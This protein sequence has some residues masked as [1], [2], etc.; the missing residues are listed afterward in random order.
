MTS[1]KD[2]KRKGPDPKPI[3]RSPIASTTGEEQFWMGQVLWI[4][5]STGR[6]EGEDHS[7]NGELQFESAGDGAADKARIPCPFCEEPVF[8]L[9]DGQ[10]ALGVFAEG[11]CPHCGIRIRSCNPEESAL[12]TFHPW[13]RE[14]LLQID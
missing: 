8:Q 2:E 10:A 1:M 5:G 6:R 14:A 11:H 12:G 9:E 13:P 4:E 7:G 3:P